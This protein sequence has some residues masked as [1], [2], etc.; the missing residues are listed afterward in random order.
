[1]R[2]D[3]IEPETP[4]SVKKNYRF[5]FL[6]KWLILPSPTSPTSASADSAYPETD[7]ETSSN[8]ATDSVH[9]T[10]SYSTDSETDSATE[11]SSTD[12]DAASSADSSPTIGSG[13]E[14]GTNDSKSV[15]S[16]SLS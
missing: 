1:M 12:A 7:S 13:P 8:T 2:R 9:E 14:E 5:S 15:A 6:I 4:M 3:G 10:D 11:T 16:K